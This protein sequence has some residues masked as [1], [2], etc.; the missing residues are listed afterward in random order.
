MKHCAIYSIKL[1]KTLSTEIEE[2]VTMH[3]TN[4][5]NL[6]KK[7]ETN[8]IHSTKQKQ[9]QETNLGL[10]KGRKWEGGGINQEVGL[11]HTYYSI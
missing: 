11:A 10:P 5:W 3:M 7:N 2:K 9:T 6:K 8:E 1:N 4:M